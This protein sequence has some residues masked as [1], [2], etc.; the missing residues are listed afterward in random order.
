LIKIKESFGRAGL[1]FGEEGGVE[2][3]INSLLKWVQTDLADIIAVLS[4]VSMI[5]VKISGSKS[6]RWNVRIGDAML[7]SR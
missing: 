3:A 5:C 7:G 4:T 6:T 2:A 1:D